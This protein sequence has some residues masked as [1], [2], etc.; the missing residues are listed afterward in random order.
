MTTKKQ[1]KELV[2][3][4]LES[5]FVNDSKSEYGSL[6]NTMFYSEYPEHDGEYNG[7]FELEV[8]AK[9]SE[10]GLIVK[11][12]DNHGGEGEGSQY[13]SVYSFTKDNQTVHVKFNGWYTSHYG[14]EFTE[15][16]FVKPKK[17]TVTQFVQE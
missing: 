1:L 4:F 12:E 8:L 11:F 5:Y 15:W 16:F 7:D 2:A 6:A 17:V 9:E 3:S 10:L 13:W 14:S